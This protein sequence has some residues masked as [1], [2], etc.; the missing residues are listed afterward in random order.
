MGGVDGGGPSSKA[1]PDASLPEMSITSDEVNFLVYRYHFQHG[2]AWNDPDIL[3]ER[4]SKRIRHF[5]R[6]CCTAPTPSAALPVSH[7]APWTPN[8]SGA[9]APSSHAPG[10]NSRV[11][12]T[13]SC[14]DASLPTVAYTQW[15]VER[16]RCFLM[17]IC[18]GGRE[19]RSGG[20][21]EHAATVARARAAGGDGGGG[22]APTNRGAVR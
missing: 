22:V 14:S 9:S 7:H 18:T 1:R 21:A 16:L 3:S 11:F 19:R 17:L 10:N 15:F 5:L 4:S 2:L 12:T 8:P 6:V 13:D 20:A